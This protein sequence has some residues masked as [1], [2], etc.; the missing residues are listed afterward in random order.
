[1]NKINDALIEY[2]INLV[3]LDDRVK[4]QKADTFFNNLARH[5]GIYYW[6]QEHKKGKFKLEGD[7][8]RKKNTQTNSES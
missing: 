5:L 4:L 6:V 7:E 3:L 1:A 2:D 8:K